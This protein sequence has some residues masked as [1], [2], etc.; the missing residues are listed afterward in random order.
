MARPVNPD[1]QRMAAL[2]L[3]HYRGKP[4]GRCHGT[5]RYVSTGACVP[6]AS[7]PVERLQDIRARQVEAE[8]ERRAPHD[9]R[10]FWRQKERESD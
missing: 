3:P 4:C 10:E 5:L 9:R 1:K 6:C 8:L 2:G 7:R